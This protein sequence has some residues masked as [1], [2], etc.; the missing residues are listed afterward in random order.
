M[1][2]QNFCQ[3][4]FPPGGGGS[5]SAHQLSI[6]RTRGNTCLHECRSPPGHITA[7]AE[8]DEWSYAQVTSKPV[9]GPLT[10]AELGMLQSR[11][12]FDSNTGDVVTFELPELG[13][14]LERR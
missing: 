2:I 1:G 10:Q 13:A 7:Q 5:C 6:C 8:L 9:Y 4:D 14:A 12:Y 3:C 11:R